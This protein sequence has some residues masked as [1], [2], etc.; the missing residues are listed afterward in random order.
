MQQSYRELPPASELWEQFDY[1]PLTGELIWRVAKPGRKAQTVAGSLNAK[2]YL[3]V[4]GP[5]Y[6]VHRVIWCWVKGSISNLVTVDHKN[7]C[8]SDNAWNNL[9]LADHTEQ[10]A[11]STT[12]LRGVEKRGNRYRVRIQ[13]RGTMTSLGTFATR[14]EAS[15]A[16]EKAHAL[17]HGAFSP[18]IG[19]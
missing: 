19:T 10:Q 9:R 8:R 4:G 14:E 11:N 15:A 3:V 12:R 13:V 5:R 2:G 16:Y 18:Y 6:R 17:V 7:L 1:K